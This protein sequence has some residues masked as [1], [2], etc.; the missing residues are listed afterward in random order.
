LVTSVRLDQAATSPTFLQGVKS[1]EDVRRSVASRTV[2]K[3]QH[4]H[5][6]SHCACQQQA[7]YL[8]QLHTV[9]IR[10]VTLPTVESVSEVRTEVTINIVVS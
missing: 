3:C 4:L 10:Y 5:I 6:S 7:Q 8:P 1:E 2:P 9:A